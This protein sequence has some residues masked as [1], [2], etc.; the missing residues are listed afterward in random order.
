MEFHHCPNHS[1]GVKMIPYLITDF[2]GELDPNVLLDDG[3][4]LDTVNPLVGERGL[5]MPTDPVNAPYYFYY[6]HS[7][8]P[9]LTGV[10]RLEVTAAMDNNLNSFGIGWRI[11]RNG[12]LAIM[13]VRVNYGTDR[14]ELVQGTAAPHIWQT[15]ASPIPVALR[16]SALLRPFRLSLDVDVDTFTYKRVRLHDFLDRTLPNDY[17]YVLDIPNTPTTDANPNGMTMKINPQGMNGKV[18]VAWMDEV[19]I[20]TGIA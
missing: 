11:V 18:G 2:E 8:L 15:V 6:W 20:F 5:K 13:F 7:N 4:V 12:Q 9:L 1:D 10:V 3:Y 17:T 16:N 19:K 14:I